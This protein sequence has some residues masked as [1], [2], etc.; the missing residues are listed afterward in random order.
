MKNKAVSKT[1]RENAV[2]A[3]A[4]LQN[5][6]YGMSRQVEALKADGKEVVVDRCMRGSDG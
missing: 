3:L 6:P 1:M 5:C 4:E 2:E